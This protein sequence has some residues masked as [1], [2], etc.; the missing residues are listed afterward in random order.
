MQ[1]KV[2]IIADYVAIRDTHNAAC[3]LTR[4]IDSF[5]EKE[6]NKIPWE[7]LKQLADARQML[8]KYVWGDAH[9]RAWDKVEEI[10]K[11]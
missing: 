3:Q 6:K 11:S 9:H 5:I 10:L 7:E 1:E 2:K 4:E 8:S